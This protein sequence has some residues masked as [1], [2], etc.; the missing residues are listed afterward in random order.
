MLGVGWW[1]DLKIHKHCAVMRLNRKC[2]L[3]YL[4][5]SPLCFTHQ[6]DTWR[7]GALA[8]ALAQLVCPAMMRSIFSLLS[9]WLWR[10][11]DSQ[12]CSLCLIGSYT[13]VHLEARICASCACVYWVLFVH[14]HWHGHT[15]CLTFF[16]LSYFLLPLFN[17]SYHWRRCLCEDRI[18]TH[19]FSDVFLS[20]ST[21]YIS[22]NASSFIQFVWYP[23]FV[24]WPHCCSL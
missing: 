19:I 2:W 5:L 10:I 23:L 16:A 6:S 15:P 13:T 12:R 21:W 18:S 4:H 9:R 20:P 17:D 8:L 1:R 22:W 3:D 24:S 11:S 14:G 7:G